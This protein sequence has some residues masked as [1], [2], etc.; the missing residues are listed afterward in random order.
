MY[1]FCVHLWGLYSVVLQS[2]TRQ[3]RAWIFAFLHVILKLKYIQKHNKCRKCIIFSAMQ[4]LSQYKILLFTCISVKYWATRTFPRGKTSPTSPAHCTPNNERFE[5][6]LQVYGI[7]WNG[8]SPHM[9]FCRS[10]IRPN[11]TKPFW[12]SV[13]HVRHT[14]LSV[15]IC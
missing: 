13:F 11:K 14:W 3:N 6:S 7:S 8:Q 1:V 10:H 2:G 15:C 5:F 9:N 12:V 4:K